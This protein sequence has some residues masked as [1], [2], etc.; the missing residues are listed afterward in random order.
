[1]LA[2]RRELKRGGADGSD[3]NMSYSGY[4]NL[5]PLDSHELLSCNVRRT[6]AEPKGYN[7]PHVFRVRVADTLLF[8]GL[9]VR[10]QGDTPSQAATMQLGL[11]P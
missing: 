4:L 1:M 3:S 2:E 11:E 10:Y 6:N 8:P 7:D 5:R 9:L